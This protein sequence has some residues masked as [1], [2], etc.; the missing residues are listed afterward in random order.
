[1]D[2]RAWTTGFGMDVAQILAMGRRWWW[3]LALGVL[4]SIAGYG[5]AVRVRGE[6]VHPAYESSQTFFVTLPPLPASALTADPAKQPWELDR[7]MATYAQMAKSQAVAK[8]AVHDG[9]LDVAPGELAA[10]TTTGTFGYTQL[11]RIGVTAGNSADA[12]RRTTAVVRA[13]ADVRAEQSIP[14][15]ASLFET[16]PAVRVDRP[17]PMAV[18]LAITM[19]AGLVAS[20]GVVFAFEHRRLTTGM[21]PSTNGQPG[22]NV[23]APATHERA[24]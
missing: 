5:V 11:L 15:S 23:R 2:C 19:L 12:E 13:F 21:V 1:M 18:N 16:S 17:T 22:T 6:S 9:G 14:G 10:S 7:L 20:A 4:F 3:L 8:R 24:F